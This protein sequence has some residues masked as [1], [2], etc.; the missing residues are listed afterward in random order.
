MSNDLHLP[1]ATTAGHAE[2]SDSYSRQ[3][4]GSIMSSWSDASPCIEGVYVHV[5]FCAHRCHYCDFFTVAD[6]DEQRDVFVNRLLSEL[7]AI[8][9]W[10]GPQL[11]TIFVG[12][13]T[14]TYLL[15]A[16][17]RRMLS[18]LSSR[19]NSENPIEFTVE[20]N[21]ETITE[22]V[23]G[24]LAEGGVNRVSLGAQSFDQGLLSTL[25]R[26]HD[27]ARVTR[28]IELIHAAGISRTS[29]DLIFGI[30]G[31]DLIRWEADLDQAIEIGTG[32]LSCYGL[33]YEP[34]TPLR[35]RRDRGEIDP[36]E[37]DLEAA[38]YELTCDRLASHG[39]RQYEISNWARPGE[40]C[41]HNLLYWQT[42][43]WW[44][45]GPSAS[46]HVE[47]WRWRNL[48]RLQTYLEGD[49]LPYIRDVEHLDE[50]G[51]VGEWFMMGL[52]LME[53][54]RREEVDLKLACEGGQ[55]RRP[56]IERHLDQ[57]LLVWEGDRLAL[58]PRGILLANIV[59]AD[60]LGP[61]RES[62]S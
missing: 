37:E 46:G 49:G 60:L 54:L 17:L 42:R 7:D 47:G 21:P 8:P 31:Q 52:R 56:I 55:R 26:R 14:P 51:Q 28:S 11:R 18:A 27:P 61:A 50:D 40:D 22:E 58:T 5:P 48:P 33:I 34:G 9:D 2:G 32:H 24:I 25:E 1:Q 23:A 6:Q 13:G 12:G 4:A 29:L 38:M 53:G 57:E 20:A 19:F 15:P 10:I 59:T 3:T 43:N 35:V 44:P 16:D 45:I 39:L 62:N 41:Q 30:P 36:V